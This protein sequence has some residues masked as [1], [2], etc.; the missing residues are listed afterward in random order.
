MRAML[1]EIQMPP[2]IVLRVVNRASV[3]PASRSSE[4][5]P[6]WKIHVQ[7]KPTVLRVELAA[8][9]RPRR[10][11]PK[12]QLKKIGVSHPSKIVPI[13]ISRAT[14]SVCPKTNRVF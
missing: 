6:A 7:I 5:A 4:P 2:R 3:T 1:E 8:R 14:L 12:R 10:R 11:K 9:H 13:P